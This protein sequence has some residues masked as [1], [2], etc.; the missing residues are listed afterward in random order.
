MEWT[1]V[2]KSLR[3]VYS[4]NDDAAVLS[5]R[6]VLAGIG[7]AG[8]FVVAGST[9]LASSPAEARV[10]TPAIEPEAAPADAAKAE[11]AKC[12]CSKDNLGDLD[13]ADLTEFS[14]QWRRRYYGYGPRRRYWRRRRRRY[15]RRRY[16]RRGY[17]RVV[18]R[19]R[20]YRGRLVRVCRR[21]W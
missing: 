3:S 9:L 14:A 2:R 18:C 11:V 16:W 19:R 5:R 12:D 1:N 8:A 13:T 21:V 15:W 20:W 17:W 7:L 10:D 4:G 6:D